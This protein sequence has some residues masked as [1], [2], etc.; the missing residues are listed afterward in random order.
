M[1]I[2]TLIIFSS[3]LLAS[4]G[5]GLIDHSQLV[6]E[7]Q[8]TEGA[9]LI[10]DAEDAPTCLAANVTW[11]DSAANNDGALNCTGGGGTDGTGTAIDPKVV[12]FDGATTFVT[13][14]L[15]ADSL[16][17]PATTWIAW[18][19]PAASGLSH[20][21]S[22]DDSDFNRALVTET[23]YKVANGTALWNSTANVTTT[24]TWQYIAVTMSGSSITLS[25]NG[26]KFSTSTAAYVD[27][28]ETFTIGKSPGANALF[29]NGDIGWVAVYPKVL[30]DDEI[31]ETC[32][33]LKDRFNGA[34]CN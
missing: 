12:T 14:A 23:T 7:A 24:G 10:L 27:N 4:C 20:I 1:N 9:S 21:L 22:L 13:T 28:T 6:P 19:K 34:S 31:N 32:L 26:T 8:I 18:V 5:D 3:F 29:F 16:T 11:P 30:T 17:M 15:D 33:A 25:K 2:K